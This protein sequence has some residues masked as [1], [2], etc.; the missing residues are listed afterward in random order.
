MSYVNEKGGGEGLLESHC[1]G[2][3]RGLRKK[4][5]S[6]FVDDV[7][8]VLPNTHVGGFIWLCGS[9]CRQ[10]PSPSWIRG[11]ALLFNRIEDDSAG[12]VCETG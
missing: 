7:A 1:G 11:Q 10:T 5:Q 2:D 12:H 6:E 3:W 9:K 4:T 8:Q